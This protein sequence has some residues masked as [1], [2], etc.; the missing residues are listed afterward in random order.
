MNQKDHEIIESIERHC[1][2]IER[3]EKSVQAFVDDTL[4]C[5]RIRDH[6]RRL[7]ENHSPPYPAL[8][9][10][11]VGV[12]DIIQVDGFL[13]RCGSAF[14][15]EMLTSAEAPLI[16]SLKQAGAI[17]AG[18]T[19]TTEFAISDPGPTCNPLNPAHT[20]GGSSSGSA[21][22]VAADFCDLAIGTQTA[23][24]VIRPAAYCGVIG[25]K[26]SFGRISTEGVF[27]YSPTLDHVG[28][29]ARHID[30]IDRAM[31]VIDADW[32]PGPTIDAREIRAAIPAG[33][34]LEITSLSA[35]Q[36]F[37][38][39]IQK[40]RDANF[41]VE[42][43][44]VLGNID[45]YNTAIDQLG[46]AEVYRI[47]EPWFDQ[48]RDRYRP[49]SLKELETGKA[50]SD[51]KLLDLQRAARQAQLKMQ[52]T[53]HDLA[54]DVWL[55]PAAPDVAPEG[56]AATGDHRMNSIWS[57]TGLPVVTI[58]TGR[59]HQNLAYGLQIVGRYGHDESLLQIAKQLQ[60][61]C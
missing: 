52:Q 12:K 23:G 27:S 10:V 16:T 7:Q 29:Y 32:K 38:A 11:L 56:L 14:P 61:Q 6:F 22:A 46:A 15:V 40:F 24:S 8:F 25:Y 3:D 17:I 30:D 53:M 21:A 41:S 36:H 31:A 34:Y 18:K 39:V 58:P 26:P 43:R 45:Q 47:H 20:P 13:T 19:H 44:Q 57:Y 54:V 1:N 2:N 37:D 60:Q 49:L 48:F 5:A 9:G 51:D 50:I 59:N 4:D 55:A 35:R 33:P 28:L 42:P